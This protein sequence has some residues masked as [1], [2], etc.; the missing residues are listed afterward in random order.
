MQS[1]KC[2]RRGLPRG[3][4]F[5][6]ARFWS[7]FP[8]AA[9]GATDRQVQRLARRWDSA[10]HERERRQPLGARPVVVVE[11]AAAGRAD[12]RAADGGRDGG[13]ADG[14]M[15]G[16][17]LAARERSSG[18]GSGAVSR[19]RRDPRRVAWTARALV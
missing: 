10:L 4:G 3:R 8:D 18:L 12:L 6:I 7:L 15:R 1:S 17:R 9:R 5:L 16:W 2:G 14:E 13:E 19:R 11:F